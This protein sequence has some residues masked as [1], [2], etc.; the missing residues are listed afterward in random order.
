MAPR[1]VSSRTTAATAFVFALILSSTALAQGPA[2]WTDFPDY[3]PGSTAYITGSGFGSNEVVTLLCLHVSGNNSGPGHTPWTTNTDPNGNFSTSWF[4]DPGDSF[5]ETFILTANGS[6][7]G[8]QAA[9]TF[10]DHINVDFRQAANNDST[11]N[12]LPAGPVIGNV[13][14]L[15]SVLQNQ[16]SIYHE[17]MIVPQRVIF[18]EISPTANNVHTLV[19]WHDALKNGR[20]AYDFLASWP[21]AV[22]TANAIAAGQGLMYNLVN[23]E[24]GCEIG[25]PSGGATGLETICANLHGGGGFTAFADCPDNMG[26]VG[27]DDVAA[28]VAA[29]EVLFGNRQI[30]I[31]ANAPITVAPTCTF[32]GYTGA[33]PTANYALTWTSAATEVIV[34]FGGHLAITGLAANP[35]AYSAGAGTISGNPYHFSLG[36]IDTTSLGNQDNQ[37]RCTEIIPTGNVDGLLAVECGG[38]HTYTATAGGFPFDATWSIGNNTAGATFVGPTGCTGVTS[39]AV[40]L[41]ATHCGS[42]LLSVAFNVNGGTTVVNLQVSVTD[43]N[44]PSITCPADIQLACG[45]SIDPLNTGGATGSDTCGAVTVT[46]TDSPGQPSC[47]GGSIIRTW[48]ATDSCLNTASCTQTITFVDGIPPSAQCP[49]SLTVQCY[50]LVP[51]PDP[52]LVTTSD[53]C[54]GAV[55]VIHLGDSATNGTEDCENV[56]TRTYQ[57]TD[58]CGN[59]TTCTQTILVDDSTAPTITCPAPVN[60]ECSSQVPSPNP[61]SVTATDNCG[62]A[63]TV[64]HFGD[65][66]N[67]GPACNYTI[68][69]TYKAQDHCGNMAF[70]TQ[71]ITVQDVTAPQITCPPDFTLPCG[72]PTDPTVTGFATATDNCGTIPAPTFTDATAGSCPSPGMTITRTWTATDGCNP[73][74]CVQIITLTP[75]P[76]QGCV[77]ASVTDLGGSCGAPAPKLTAS[78]PILSAY[79]AFRIYNGPPNEP[80]IFAADAPPFAVPTPL[81]GSCVLFVDPMDSVV[82]TGFSTDSNGDWTARFEIAGTNTQLINTMIRVQ[83]GFLTPQLSLT[84]GLEVFFGTCPPFC[85]ATKD[86]YAGAGFAGQVFDVNFLSVFPTGMD[87]GTYDTSGGAAPPNGLRWDGTVAGR[88]ALKTFLAGAGGASGP[89]AND[90][91][92]P[93]TTLGGGSLALQ[94]A[95]LSL[96]VAFNNANVLGSGLPGFANQVYFNYPGNPDSLNGFNVTQILAVANAALATGAL[97]A[98]YSFDSLATLVQNINEAYDGCAESFWGSKYLFAPIQ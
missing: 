85:T 18:S 46:Y 89:L 68:T 16:N 37:I 54:G 87:V 55:T 32:T 13:H 48:T 84:N 23:N 90:G 82:V 88:A 61:A 63:V 21:Q 69:R 91:L 80:L 36:H 83:G 12:C 47:A 58:P 2:V 67:G 52:S 22:T 5:G 56:I 96:N 74:S 75:P 81:G 53:N 51:S 77:P 78:P 6:P 11:N 34:E 62:G 29:F 86:G 45:D 44:P 94:A 28:R 35:L 95:T 65:V 26:T 43:V 17:G 3:A 19:F 76:N 30:K 57:A 70:C 59:T 20:H 24:C 49:S 7:S 93:L 1:I 42:F 50:S 40:Q 79:L 41:A 4:V 92:N 33:N 66:P 98:G 64:T 60:I 14:W 27:G 25:P 15:N 71:L 10:T 97:P 31:Y 73:V 38:N 39:C 9:T 72:T 8:L